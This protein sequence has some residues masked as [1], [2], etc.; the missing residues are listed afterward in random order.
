MPAINK[1]FTAFLL[2]STSFAIDK[3]TP[4][5]P[6]Q[7]GCEWDYDMS[8]N[9][10]GYM[11]K[12]YSQFRLVSVD[13]VL[14]KIS[15][16][17][18]NRIADAPY[19]SK[20]PRSTSPIN[21]EAKKSDVWTIAKQTDTT[22]FV[23]A[24]SWFSI[25]NDDLALKETQDTI[26]MFHPLMLKSKGILSDYFVGGMV[27]GD[28]DNKLVKYSCPQLDTNKPLALIQGHDTISVTFLNT[29]NPQY[30]NSFWINDLQEYFSGKIDSIQIKS[31]NGRFSFVLQK[32]DFWGDSKNIHWNLNYKL[33]SPEQGFDKIIITGFNKFGAVQDTL[34]VKIHPR[35]APQ[36][37][38]I[39][40]QSYTYSENQY[41]YFFYQ[42][43]ST[44]P[45]DFDTIL[46]KS[47]HNNVSAYEGAPQKYIGSDFIPTLQISTLKNHDVT[48][49]LF[50][51][52]INSAGTTYDTIPVFVTKNPLLATFSKLNSSKNQNAILQNGNLIVNTDSKI[53]VQILDVKGNIVFQ[54]QFDK[55]AV[56]PLQLAPSTYIIRTQPVR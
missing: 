18:E 12:K 28:Y 41:T 33:L 17:L 2:F 31:V 34:N 44:K 37:I 20:A 42:S 4:L 6:T 52:L 11:S 55:S 38:S 26:S 56:S 9:G 10:R 23:V 21:Y 13:T 36:K 40:K 24:G 19:F 32:N 30:D 43:Y 39:S 8:S 25:S 46:I 1:L 51:T 35:L 5:I 7:I 45:S 48:D 3:N 27:Y 14:N 22:Q 54:N 15:Y 29:K 47:L 49:S 53:N 16:H 50:I